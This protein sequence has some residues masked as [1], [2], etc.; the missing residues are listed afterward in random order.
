MGVTAKERARPASVAAAGSIPAISTV[1]SSANGM[2]CKGERLWF[3]TRRTGF[4]SLLPDG[5]WFSSS[6]G[7]AAL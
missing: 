2:W 3:G 4:E 1:L 5:K 6:L 7:R